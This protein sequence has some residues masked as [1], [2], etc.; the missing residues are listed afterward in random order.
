MISPF[1]VVCLPYIS[2][3]RGGVVSGVHECALRG[4]CP[5]HSRSASLGRTPPENGKAGA[6]NAITLAPSLP[7]AGIDAP[8]DFQCARSVPGERSGLLEEGAAD[9]RESAC[10]DKFCGRECGG[11][12]ESCSGWGKRQKS[13][14]Q[15]LSVILL[16][17]VMP[18]TRKSRANGALDARGSD[19]QRLLRPLVHVRPP[20][21]QAGVR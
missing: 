13:R 10:A 11:G 15:T 1:Q 14:S 6:R 12:G 8:R 7:S 18:T 3:A 4:E 5:T 16:T 19:C 21:D 2:E 9:I 20:N 17:P